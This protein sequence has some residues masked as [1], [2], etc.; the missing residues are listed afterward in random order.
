MVCAGKTQLEQ[1]T[2]L[3]SR[4][5]LDVCLGTTLSRKVLDQK[6]NIRESDRM[7]RPKTKKWTHIGTITEQWVKDSYPNASATSKWKAQN[8]MNMLSETSHENRNF[9][10]WQSI[11]TKKDMFHKPHPKQAS[12]IF[13]RHL[14]FRNLLFTILVS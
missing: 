13:L 9:E 2:K 1:I 3:S 6:Q 12:C 5:Y 10:G 14:V 4:A 8:T 7:P 11:E